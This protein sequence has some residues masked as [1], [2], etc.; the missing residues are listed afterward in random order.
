M[1]RFLGEQASM[2]AS[3]NQSAIAGS[4]QAWMP[5]LPGGFSFFEGVATRHECDLESWTIG[6]WPLSYRRKRFLSC[7]SMTNLQ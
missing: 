2:P 7:I 4:L 3:L 5:A 6:H 1:D